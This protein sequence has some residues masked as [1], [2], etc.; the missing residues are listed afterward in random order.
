MLKRSITY[1]N[2]NKEIVTEDFYFNLSKPE[3]LELE[4]EIDGGFGEMLQTIIKSENARDLL[5][6]F[7]RIVI[8]SYGIKSDDGRRFEKS[9]AIRTEFEQTAAYQSLFMELA[10]DDKAAV[11]FLQGVLPKDMQGDQD[12]P[13]VVPPKPPTPPTS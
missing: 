7:K 8:M 13:V 1:E 6:E 9:D 4:V 5:R 2:F 10:M 12:K 11:I 3:L